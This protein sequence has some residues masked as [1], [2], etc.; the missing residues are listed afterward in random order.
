MCAADSNLE[1]THFPFDIAEREGNPA[2]PG[3]GTK[4]VCRNYEGLKEWAQKFRVGDGTGI[5]V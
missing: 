5:N 1:D 3:W 4:R 2:A